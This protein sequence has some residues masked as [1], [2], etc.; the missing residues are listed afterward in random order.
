LPTFYKQLLC[1]FPF[2]KKNADTKSNYLKAVQNDFVQ[3]GIFKMLVKLTSGGN[4][5][6]K[7][8]L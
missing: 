5:I 4:T 2:G 1:Q 3:K 7:L 6:K 8:I